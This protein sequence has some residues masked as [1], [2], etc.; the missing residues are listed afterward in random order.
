LEKRKHGSNVLVVKGPEYIQKLEQ[1]VVYL[2]Q[3][4]KKAE[5]SNVFFKTAHEFKIDE[6][7]VLKE[8]IQSS[9][10]IVFPKVT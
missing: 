2:R 1:E 10:D 8:S 6:F 5:Q 4:L 9:I 3:E 7:N